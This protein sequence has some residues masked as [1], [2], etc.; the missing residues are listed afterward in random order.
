[1]PTSA[2]PR[3]PRLRRA[4]RRLAALLLWSGAVL[5]QAQ[6]LAV[7][8]PDT[9]EPYRSVF[10]EI[11]EGVEE[12]AR[13]RVRAYPVAGAPAAGVPAAELQAALKGSKAVIALGRQGVKAASA[14]EA[15]LPVVAGA[16]SAPPDP[17]RQA[18]ISLAPDPALLFARLKSLLPGVRRVLAVYQ[19]Q[20]NEALMRLAR[21]AARSAGLELLALEAPDL[22]AAARRYESLFAAADARRDALWLPQDSVSADESTLLPMILKECWNRSL[23]LFSSSYV[24]VRQGALFALYPNHVELGRDLAALALAMA[25]GEPARR[26]MAPLRAVRTAFNSRTASHLGLVPSP[27]LQREF[28]A[29]FPQP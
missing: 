11:I 8:Y 10:M 15:A 29:I 3:P 19:P 2:L 9:G 28:D 24:H 14:L 12:Q 7:L 25:G 1:M 20:Q 6:G 17:D 26:G 16:V 23:P 27:A 22:A 5:A 21:D 4:A 18:G 13:A